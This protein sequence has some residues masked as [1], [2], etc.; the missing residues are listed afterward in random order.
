MLSS[1]AADT[2]V[3]GDADSGHV[4]LAEEC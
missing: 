3:Q 4:L 2:S 1:L